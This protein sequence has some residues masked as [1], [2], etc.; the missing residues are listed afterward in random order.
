MNLNND[1]L[2]SLATLR[3]KADANPIHMPTR[4][5]VQHDDGAEQIAALEAGFRI[6]VQEL[7]VTLHREEGH[8][9]NETVLHLKLR[10]TSGEKIQMEDLQAIANGL[11]FGPLSYHTTLWVETFDTPGGHSADAG[12]NIEIHAVQKV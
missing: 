2:Q 12:A 10:H 1:E 11:G 5:H 7:A 3:Q 4:V 6:H 8:P 9:N